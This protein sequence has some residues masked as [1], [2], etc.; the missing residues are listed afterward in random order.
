MNKMKRIN[1]DDS[2]LGASRGLNLHKSEL[3]EATAW[4]HQSGCTKT[5]LICKIVPCDFKEIHFK[6]E[7]SLIDDVTCIEQY[8]SCEIAIILK[9]QK[10]ISL[11]EG[12]QL[13]SAEIK[14]CLG[15]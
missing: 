12:K 1:K 15:L 14:A 4:T 13:K 2:K 7:V 10:T 5:V 3:F 8:T 9:C 11:S 6:G